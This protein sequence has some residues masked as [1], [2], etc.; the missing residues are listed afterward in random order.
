[1]IVIPAIDIIG[2]KAVRLSGGDFNEKK[3]YHD[4]PADVARLFD[5]AG[6]TRL[7]LVD[8]DGAKNKKI[9]NL[10]ILEKVSQ[11]T[12]LQIDFGGGVGTFRDVQDVLNAGASQCTVGSMAAKQPDV[13]AGWVEHFGADKFLVGADVLDETI[14]ISGWLED[15]GIPLF[16]FLEDMQQLGIKEFFCTD[17]SKDGMMQ[18]PSVELYKKIIQNF[19]DIRLIASGGITSVADLDELKAAGCSGAIVGKA[20]YEKQIPIKALSEFQ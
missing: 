11:V 7:H 17:I 4:D 2:G 14:K 19:K 3:V 20:I 5:D 13:F 18:G 16:T 10:K 9:T 15:T 8:L 1:M 12:D 6:F